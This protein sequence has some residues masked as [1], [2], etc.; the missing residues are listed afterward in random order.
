[1][2]RYNYYIHEGQYTLEPHGNPAGSVLCKT[3]EQ[4]EAIL[5][6]M[7]LMNPIVIVTD[8]LSDNE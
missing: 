5:Q 3:K 8:E 6:H 4:A 1:M 7:A 2:N